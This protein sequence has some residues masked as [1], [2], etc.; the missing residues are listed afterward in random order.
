MKVLSLILVFFIVFLPFFSGTV[1]ACEKPSAIRCSHNMSC[2]HKSP[3]RKSDCGQ[4]GSCAF[5]FACGSCG[6]LKVDGIIVG[7]R[8]LLVKNVLDV[9]AQIGALSSYSSD[10]WHPPKA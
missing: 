2:D 1:K 9:P 10:S 3:E 6:F 5:M 7:I 4:C 8:S